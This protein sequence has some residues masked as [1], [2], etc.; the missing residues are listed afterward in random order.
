MIDGGNCANIVAKTALKNNGLKVEL[1]PHPYNMNWIDKVIQSIT[2]HCQFP[3]HMSN[4]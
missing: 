1:H 3:I 4:Y 2:Q